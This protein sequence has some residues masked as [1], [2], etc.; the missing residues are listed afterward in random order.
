MNPIERTVANFQE[1][2]AQVPEVLQPVIVVI[3]AA[4]PFVEGEGGAAIGIV[5]GLHPVVAAVAAAAGNFLCV[6]LVVAVTSRARTA[7]VDRHNSLV[8]VGG[9]VSRP[10]VDEPASRQTTVAAPGSKRRQR[11]D[12]W[13]VRYG[14]PG[15]SLLGPLAI[16][17][18]FTAAILVGSGT[19]PR[20]VL[21]W[22]AIAIAVWTTVVTVGAWA[23]LTYVV[24]S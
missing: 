3:A 16:P 4:I 15:V 9:G 2:I 1:L 12:R 21:L 14:V 13:L 23:A 22:Q 20:W 11:F 5:G 18:Q 8:G 24:G 6:L 19:P 7:V 10:D 17:T